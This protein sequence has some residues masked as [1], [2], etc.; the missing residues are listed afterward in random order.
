[1][2]EEFKIKII[3]HPPSITFPLKRR[4]LVEKFIYK[5]FPLQKVFENY[6]NTI[7]T[8]GE[9]IW[10]IDTNS[11]LIERYTISIVPQSLNSD[12]TV[13]G[14]IFL[15]DRKGDRRG[16]TLCLENYLEDINKGLPCTL[17]GNE[18]SG[19]KLICSS[20]ENVLIT[21]KQYIP[22]LN[23]KIKENLHNT[24][25]DNQIGK[26]VRLK[27]L[28]KIHKRLVKFLGNN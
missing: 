23:K 18:I 26:K 16:I 3:N 22:E 1:M 25:K 5:Y 10:V 27:K 8:P 24:S 20:E 12:D 6:C 19:P 14:I 11:L 4:V 17:H 7:L 9:H 2:I 15:F 13:L 21:L 28:Q